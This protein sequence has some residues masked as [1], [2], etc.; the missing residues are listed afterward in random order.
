MDVDAANS[1]Q[2]A[3]QDRCQ[4][5]RQLQ[6]GFVENA[7]HQRQQPRSE[8]K[9]RRNSNP[10]ALASL[11]DRHSSGRNLDSQAVL[12]DRHNSGRSFNAKAVAALKHVSSRSM[13]TLL[14]CPLRPERAE[15]IGPPSSNLPR[16]EVVPPPL[17]CVSAGL[18]AGSSSSKS[19]GGLLGA[20]R[21]G[22]P[23][24]AQ[25]AEISM[26]ALA[27]D[28]PLKK[29]M[30]PP[31]Q[32]SCKVRNPSEQSLAGLASCQP[33]HRISDRRKASRQLPEC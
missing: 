12:A 16:S 20:H 7:M 5:R 18:A 8:A 29:R 33:I 25:L 2:S 24:V 23:P 22:S 11:A 10:D 30:L 15:N 27:L 6:R 14:N 9:T 32:H 21:D 13:P 19:S 4:Q 3:W 31:L 1:E 28:V 17:Q 26:P